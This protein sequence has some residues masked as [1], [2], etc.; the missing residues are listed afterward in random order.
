MGDLGGIVDS[1][2]GQVVDRHDGVFVMGGLAFVEGPLIGTDLDGINPSYL[3]E[4]TCLLLAGK[5]YDRETL[6]LEVWRIGVEEARRAKKETRRQ[7]KARARAV[8]TAHL[9]ET[10]LAEFERS[11][12]FHVVGAD[13][14]TYLITV[15]DQHNVYRIENGR[16]TFEYCI[17]TKNNV[18][19]YDQMLAQMLLLMTNPS[20]F[21][22]IT[23]TWELDESGKRTIVHHSSDP[24][25]WLR[26]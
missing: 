20:M 5:E 14:Y 9:D 22:E 18:P 1:E 10:Q 12:S 2:R 6:G 3:V 21:H 24:A 17:V 19:T 4:Q 11:G 26:I 7:I 16:R 15:A 8:L 25:G 13:G 23:N